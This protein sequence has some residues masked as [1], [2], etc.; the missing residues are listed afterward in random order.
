MIERLYTHTISVYRNSPTL[1]DGVTTLY[2]HLIDTTYPQSVVIELS[3]P[4]GHAS[5]DVVGLVSGVTT[6]STVLFSSGGTVLKKQTDKSFDRVISITG[7]TGSAASVTAKTFGKTGQPI[8]T[9]TTV[10]S[11]LSCRIDNVGSGNPRVVNPLVLR[12]DNML[13]FLSGANV[14]ENSIR[15]DDIVVES[16]T[17]D[18]TGNGSASSKRFIVKNINSYYDRTSYKYTE[19]ELAK[20]D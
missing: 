1:L 11:G 17:L 6:T 19:L 3:I 5:F 8:T 13:C 15:V 7:T 18:E 9:E 10:Y 20:L 12:P 16:G 14:V 4:S 2:T